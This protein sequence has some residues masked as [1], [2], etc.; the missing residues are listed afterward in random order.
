LINYVQFCGDQ[1]ITNFVF[2]VNFCETH[3][4]IG[5]AMI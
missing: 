2:Y 4:I 3:N 5:P 1:K